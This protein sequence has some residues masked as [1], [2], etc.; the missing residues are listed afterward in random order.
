MLL[1]S[2]TEIDEDG[3]GGGDENSFKPFFSSSSAKLFII[4]S[5]GS[6]SSPGGFKWLASSLGKASL[7][8]N[9]GAF[10]LTLTV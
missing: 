1:N 10:L 5:I 9:S 6:S 7:H 3:D 4:F 2:Y 8:Q